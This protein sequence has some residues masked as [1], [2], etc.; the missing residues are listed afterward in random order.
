MQAHTRVKKANFEFSGRGGGRGMYRQRGQEH[1]KFVFRK[2]Y[3]ES[4]TPTLKE[5]I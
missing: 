3:E 5:Y 1:P 4:F 2:L